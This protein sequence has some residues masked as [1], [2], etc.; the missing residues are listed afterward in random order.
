MQNGARTARKSEWW[1]EHHFPVYRNFRCKNIF[2][3]HKPRKFYA[4]FF[5]TR[6]NSYYCQNLFA[7]LASYFVRWP[8]LDSYLQLSDGLLGKS[9]QTR[10]TFLAAGAK[11]FRSLL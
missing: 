8:S 4:H 11:L 6:V 2:G 10:D 3:C 9:E 1:W 5:F 7:M